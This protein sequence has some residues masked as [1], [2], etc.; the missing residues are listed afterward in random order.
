MLQE[1]GH[2]DGRVEL[3]RLIR[4]L[5][6]FAV[7]AGNVQQPAVLCCRG[8]VVLICHTRKRLVRFIPGRSADGGR[9]QYM[10]APGSTA[11]VYTH[12]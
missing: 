12:P 10:E 11:A 8:A 3:P 6:S 4:G 7:I 1:V 2:S 5:G 9:V